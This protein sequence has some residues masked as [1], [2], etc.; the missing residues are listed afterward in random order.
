MA[1]IDRVRQMSGLRLASGARARAEAATAAPRVFRPRDEVAAAV[2]ALTRIASQ[3]SARRQNP[4]ALLI[5]N[6]AIGIEDVAASTAR[7]QVLTRVVHRVTVEMVNH[8]NTLACLA[9]RLPSDWLAAVVARMSARPYPLVQDCPMFRNVGTVQCERVTRGMEHAAVRWIVLASRRIGA[10]LRAMLARLSRDA[11]EC[12]S[13]ASTGVLH[14]ATQTIRRA[15]LGAEAPH[16]RAC[17]VAE[18]TPAL[19][20]L[21]DPVL[22]TVG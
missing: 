6:S 4:E 16:L 21:S 9:A 17:P 5:L 10:F 15:R 2:L 14:L 13:T 12:R 11:S 1:N 7:R 18:L 19:F 3:P 20:A 22:S 8:K